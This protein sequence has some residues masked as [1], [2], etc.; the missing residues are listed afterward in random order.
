MKNIILFLCLFFTFTWFVSAWWKE[1][2]EKRT[3]YKN[4]ESIQETKKEPLQEVKE[5]LQEKLKPQLEKIDL[6]GEKKRKIVY[7]KIIQKL[8]NLIQDEN[9]PKKNKILLRLLREIIQEKK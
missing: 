5:K 3:E 8:T 6:L 1:K 4:N 2:I 9:T 7:K